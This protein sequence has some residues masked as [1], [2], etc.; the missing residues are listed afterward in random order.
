MYISKEYQG[1]GEPNQKAVTEGEW[2][3]EWGKKICTH[4]TSSKSIKYV[5]KR[6]T[7]TRANPTPAKY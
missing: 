5:E 4:H 1:K 2:E 6:K 3:G 7:H